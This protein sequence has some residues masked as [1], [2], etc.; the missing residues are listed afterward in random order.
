MLKSAEHEIL[1]A[2]KY[3]NTKKT[4]FFAGWDKHRMLYFLLKNVK[5][6]TIVGILKF[7]SKKTVMFSWGEHENVFIPRALYADHSKGWSFW[8]LTFWKI[9]IFSKN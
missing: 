4:S 2:H 5:M 3:K 8:I 6:Q 1:N 9:I 7:M